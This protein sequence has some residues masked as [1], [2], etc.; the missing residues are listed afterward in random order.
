MWYAI[1]QK[2]GKPI[3]FNKANIYSLQILGSVQKIPRLKQP[4]L[5]QKWTWLIDFVFV[6]VYIYIY[7]Y[8][9]GAV[10]VRKK[11][12]DKLIDNVCMSVRVHIHINTHRYKIH[13]HTHSHTHTHTHIYIYIY[14]Y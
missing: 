6:C 9:Y 1:K 13:T 12:R 8:I 11:Y 10:C 2:K 3:E 14:I 7:I 5:R 4:S